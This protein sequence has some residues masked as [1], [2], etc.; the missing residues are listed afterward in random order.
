MARMVANPV[1]SATGFSLNSDSTAMSY[2]LSNS[3]K[4]PETIQLQRLKQQQQQQHL[5]QQ[6]VVVG[7]VGGVKNKSGAL[8]KNKVNTNAQPAVAVDVDRQPSFDIDLA[9]VEGASLDLFDLDLLD[10]E[11]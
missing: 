4:S 1:S 5:Q 6:Q 8:S 11:K 9:M 7:A 3:T 2:S 10:I